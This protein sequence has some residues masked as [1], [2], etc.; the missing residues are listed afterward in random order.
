MLVTEQFEDSPRLYIAR[1]HVPSELTQG[2]DAWVRVVAGI[3]GPEPDFWPFPDDERSFRA[4]RLPLEIEQVEVVRPTEPKWFSYCSPNRAYR[5]P[6][7]KFTGAV[8]LDEAIHPVEGAMRPHAGG[9]LYFKH[10]ASLLDPVEQHGT[11]ETTEE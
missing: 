5:P 4:A 6:Y 1:G 10:E 3:V 11:E 7:L 9:L 8:V 2:G